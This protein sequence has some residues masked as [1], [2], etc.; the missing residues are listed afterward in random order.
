MKNV[1]IAIAIII[2]VVLNNKV[3][4]III[5]ESSIRFRI[6][7][8]SNTIEDQIIKNNL[9][10]ELT[11]Y[12]TDLVINASSKK[13]ANDIINSNYKNIEKYIDNYLDI[14]NIKT[15]YNL[16]IGKN[17]FDAKSYKGVKYNSGYYDSIVLSLGNKKGIN[18][19]CVM[20]PPLCLIDQSEDVEYTTLVKDMLNKYKI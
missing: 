13:E 9:S 16:S 10:K 19:W 18:W 14:N 2:I 11:K 8:N 7:A 4:N 5:P 15:T 1:L 20:Y 17:Y 3:E 12:I 6:I